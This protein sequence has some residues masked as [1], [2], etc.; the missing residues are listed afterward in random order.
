MNIQDYYKNKIILI[1]GGSGFIGK[2]L[3]YKLLELEVKHIIIIDKNTH[4]NNNNNNNDNNI[5]YIKCDLL[6]NSETI[7]INQLT[8]DIM[9]HL[10]ANVST[11]D[12]TYTNSKINDNL[13]S[14]CNLIKICETNNSKLIYASSCTVYG[15]SDIPNIV[16]KEEL[17]LN[18]YAKSKL[19]MDNYIRNNKNNISI[20][21]IGI[22]YF[23]VYGPGEEHK[24]EMMSM[25]GKM[26]YNIRKN[27]NIELFEFG[28][29]SRD[30]VYI[31]DV[32]NCTLLAGI[33]NISNIY[34]CGYG[35]S[36]NF[37]YI[38]K[39]IYD[40]YKNNS[41]IIYI[42]NKYNFLQTKTCA[43][44][45]IATECINYLPLFNIHDGIQK[46]ICNI[47]NYI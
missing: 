26:I 14:F 25:I 20:P 17:P 33:S 22:R 4:D 47:N 27:N 12:N 34:N 46:Y 2:N 1:T 16:G 41:K 30:F 37:N 40:H 9:F 8:F 45:T 10:A 39:I 24:G 15:N 28:E 6:N 32:I 21:V 18:N 31:D 23:N 42:P 36:V 13:I 38:F 5:T 44:I 11:I 35:I 29:Q 7:I 19:A 43:D 3:V